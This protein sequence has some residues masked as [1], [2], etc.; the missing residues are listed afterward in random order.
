MTFDASKFGKKLNDDMRES[1][2]DI[3]MKETDEKAQK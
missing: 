2:R 1:M 3:K